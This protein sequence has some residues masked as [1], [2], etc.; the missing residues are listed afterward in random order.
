MAYACVRESVRA[1]DIGMTCEH[2]CGNAYVVAQLVCKSCIMAL[3]VH[4]GG[5]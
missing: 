4:L 2:S 1:W 5:E 3:H